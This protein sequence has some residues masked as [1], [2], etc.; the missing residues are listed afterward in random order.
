M[1]VTVPDVPVDVYLASWEQLD[2]AVRWLW[3][4]L[5]DADSELPLTSDDAA[6]TED[7]LRRYAA[8]R[9]VGSAQA[10]A[11]RSEGRRTFTLELELPQ[12][13]GADLEHLLELLDLV[14]RLLVEQN[15]APP[16]SAEIRSHRRALLGQM[17]S[18]VRQG[19]PG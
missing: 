5:G 2:E 16:A 13:S 11:A 15:L 18:Q 14:D 8:Q 10:E 1:V 6:E 3:V 12:E 9:S 19:R 17:A 7:L 4:V